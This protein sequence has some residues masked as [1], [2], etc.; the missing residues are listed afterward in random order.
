M[1]TAYN[2]SR[3]ILIPWDFTDSCNYALDY[4]QEVSS[5][6]G[7]T[8]TLLHVVCKPEDIEPSRDKLNKAIEDYTKKS[9]LKN[10]P[11]IEVIQGKVQEAIRTVASEQ[12]TTLIVMKTD[13]VKGLQKY[14][15]SHAM[16]IVA[17][18]SIPFLVVQ[19]TPDVKPFNNVVV[20]MDGRMESKEVLPWIMFLSKI[21]NFKLH[22]LKPKVND[23]IGKKYI[24]NNL[25]FVSNYLND[26][27]IEFDIQT[28]GKRSLFSSEL[29]DYAKGINANLIIL[30]LHKNIGLF[31]YLF[32][33]GEQAIIAN[34][35]KIPV[36]CINPR[37]D[38]RKYA[39]F[40]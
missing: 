1:T 35:H 7:N 6:T 15:G 9:P 28:L 34:E 11:R 23:L 24:A 19:D 3:N 32:G 8:I 39:G 5:K 21:Y 38:I 13:G 18:S 33:L 30:M 12:N 26:S 40:R 4:A 17:G 31:D 22:L 27:S 10:E 2:E 25:T 36:I 37:T 20:P 29:T 14:T 16:K